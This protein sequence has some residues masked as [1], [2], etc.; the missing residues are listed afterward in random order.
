MIMNESQP[1][2]EITRIHSY[3]PQLRNILPSKSKS[4]S[5]TIAS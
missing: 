3:E 1:Q 5:L 4:Q 2:V